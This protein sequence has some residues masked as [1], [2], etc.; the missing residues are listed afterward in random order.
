MS[1]EHDLAREARHELMAALEAWALSVR[2]KTLTPTEATLYEKYAAWRKL[3]R[4][5]GRYRFPERK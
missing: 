5:T 1:S 4:I 3:R 2:E